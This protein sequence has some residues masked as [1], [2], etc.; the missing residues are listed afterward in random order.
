VRALPRVLIKA[1]SRWVVGGKHNDAAAANLIDKLGAGHEIYRVTL[2]FKR[3]GCGRAARR[4]RY[5][6]S[7]ARGRAARKHGE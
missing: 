5:Q 2:D 4:L 7:F 6:S 3:K 1:T